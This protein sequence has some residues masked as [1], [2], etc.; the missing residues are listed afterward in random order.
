MIFQ[1]IVTRVF[2]KGDFSKAGIHVSFTVFKNPRNPGIQPHF[3]LMQDVCLFTKV[4]VFWLRFEFM[5]TI[6]EMKI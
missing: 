5:T 1:S 4:H 3:R 2:Q 6:L